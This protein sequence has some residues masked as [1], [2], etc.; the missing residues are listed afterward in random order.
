MNRGVL[1]LVVERSLGPRF[2]KSL[3]A[4]IHTAGQRLIETC[5]R[6]TINERPHRIVDANR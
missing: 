3:S 6:V 1:C 5:Q 4:A 2:T